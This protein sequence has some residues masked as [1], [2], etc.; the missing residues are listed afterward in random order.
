MRFIGLYIVGLVLGL[1][2]GTVIFPTAPAT[3]ANGV[4][5]TPKN[6][7]SLRLPVTTSSV[8]SLQQQLF[9]MNQKL[10]AGEP[11]YF[12]LDTPGG[13]IIAGE[14]LIA[15]IQGLGR[16][17]KTVVSFAASMGFMFTQSL[18]ERLILPNGTLMSHRAHI[19]L[20][21]QIPGEFNT[22]ALYWINRVEALERRVADR[23][24]LPFSDYQKLVK[25]E[26][27]VGGND[28]VKQRAADRVTNATCA[29]EMMETFGET[30]DTM[31]GPVKVLW[32]NCP[33]ITTPLG[34]DFSNLD[35]EAATSEIERIKTTIYSVTNNK[36]AFVSD[37]VLRE[38]YFRYVR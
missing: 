12:F 19:G 38:F 20:E 30:V 7:V 26:Y 23:M 36:R 33:L 17:V 9:A 37:N 8:K 6:T 10:P 14:E 18:G 5:F 11:I 34:I 27:W 31:L 1:A 2:M 25:D 28:A 3:A 13:S 16:E 4:V 35:K 32:S 24:K 15:T 22:R 29:P 21:G